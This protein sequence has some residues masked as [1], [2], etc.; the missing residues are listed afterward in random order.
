[1]NIRGPLNS[2]PISMKYEILK[3]TPFQTR[4]NHG[5]QVR[6]DQCYP[7]EHLHWCHEPVIV[8]GADFIQD[9]VNCR[10]L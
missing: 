7:T 6:T 10:C 9:I 3:I 5:L 2:T 8:L 1:M 4:R